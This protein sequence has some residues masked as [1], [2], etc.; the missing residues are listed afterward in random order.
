ELAHLNEWLAEGNQ[1]EM[2]W[3]AR[4]TERRCSPEAVL[5]GARRVVVVAKNYLPAHYELP[6]SPQEGRVSRYAVGRDY[7]R[8][9]D[10]PLKKL[11]RLC[12]ELGGPGTQSKP[13]VDHGPVMERAW[14]ERAGL[15][16]L[17][18]HTLLIHPEQGSWFFLG[19]VLTT[20]EFP[21]PER[22][23]LPGSCGNCRRCIDACPTQAI[24]EAPHRVD[25]R[26]CLSY[27]TIEHPRPTPPELARQNSEWLLGC[28]VCQE[29]CPYN[30]KRAEPAE[31]DP[32]GQMLPGTLNLTELLTIPA[33]A[34]AARFQGT[35]FQRP[36]WEKIQQTARELLEQRE[37][38]GEQ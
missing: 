38:S 6:H 19:V 27:L 9:L 8:V 11:A 31:G 5:P 10:K 23:T 16:F 24:T 28:D 4:D 35:P 25:A 26:R 33:E 3:L 1:G 18:R 29:V 7:H 37:R 36:G 30:L 17:G 32:F 12:N 14:A 13:Y 20:L 34:F 22:P 21:I 15:G 2:A